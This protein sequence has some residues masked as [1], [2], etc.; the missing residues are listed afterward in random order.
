MRQLQAVEYLRTHVV[1]RRRVVVLLAGA[2]FLFF[3]AML[4]YQVRQA[5]GW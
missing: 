3:T 4:L 2:E 1:P 5:S